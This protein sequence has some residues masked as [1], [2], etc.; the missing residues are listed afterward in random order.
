M[1]VHVHIRVAVVEQEYL[2]LVMMEK[3][4]KFTSMYVNF[5]LVGQ[6]KKS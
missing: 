4:D 2:C 1:H 6:A 3:M 5:M